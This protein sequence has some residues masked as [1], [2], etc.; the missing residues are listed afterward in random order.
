VFFI[1]RRFG[2]RVKKKYIE[3]ARASID[4][5]ALVDALENHALGEIKM[6]SSQV[7]A[8]LALLKKVM[9]DISTSPAKDEKEKGASEV[10][11]EEA[12]EELD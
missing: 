6:T 9:P 8:A 10:S 7:T 12:L 2:L 1:A 11:H 3:D 5:K 4:V